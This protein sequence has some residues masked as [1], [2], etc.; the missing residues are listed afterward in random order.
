[1]RDRAPRPTPTSACRWRSATALHWRAGGGG[2]GPAASARHG[3]PRQPHQRRFHSVV[4]RKR[5]SS[6]PPAAPESE[7]PI[8]ADPGGDQHDGGQ[9]GHRQAACASVRDSARQSAVGP[10]PSVRPMQTISH[11]TP[12]TRPHQ[13]A[14]VFVD[15]GGRDAG[16]P[17]D[18]AVRGRRI[19]PP[20]GRT[21]RRRSALSSTGAN[22]V[23][24]STADTD[25]PGG[26]G[27]QGGFG[28]DHCAAAGSLRS[29]DRLEPG[30]AQ[31]ERCRNEERRRATGQA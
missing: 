12:A 17:E 25:W 18:R 6:V 19:R 9:R 10:V 4:A 2:C 13:R 14:L 8:H 5:T 24:T 27:R 23:C 29:G 3:G 21:T 15:I 22:G 20:P 11:S 30:E 7:A 26:S 31:A 28:D 16:R 1:M